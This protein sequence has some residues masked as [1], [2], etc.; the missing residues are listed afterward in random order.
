[1]KSLLFK[2]SI[3]IVLVGI[4]Y[5]LNIVYTESS[6]SKQ[7]IEY[8]WAYDIND[9]DL[10][11]PF[12]FERYSLHRYVKVEVS[13]NNLYFARGTDTPI[14]L[15]SFNRVSGKVNW[16]IQLQNRW[17][18]DTPFIINEET[19]LLNLENETQIYASHDGSFLEK[20]LNPDS[21]RK[22]IYCDHEK[23]LFED[24]GKTLSCW[25]RINQKVI[26][27]Y[28]LDS[29][30]SYRLA[31]PW[32][33][34]YVI[35]LQ[36][37]G[38]VSL[39]SL[40]FQNGSTTEFA[41]WKES[42]LRM[43]L[44]LEDSIIWI[45]CLYRDG[46]INIESVQSEGQKQI[47]ASFPRI[48]SAEKL[49]A[50]SHSLLS[51]YEDLGI[52]LFCNQDTK[53]LCTSLVEVSRGVD[54]QIIAVDSSF[55]QIWKKEFPSVLVSRNILDKAFLDESM[56]VFQYLSRSQDSMRIA[57]SFWV[58]L[59]SGNI[60]Q[61]FY[62]TM[63]Y[64]RGA[65][66]SSILFVPGVFLVTAYPESNYVTFLVGYSYQEDLLYREKEET[67]SCHKIEL[68]SLWEK[69]YS[70]VEYC[71]IY[72]SFLYKNNICFFSTYYDPKTERREAKL[73]QYDPIERKELESIDFEKFEGYSRFC[74]IIEGD[75]LITTSYDNYTKK[76][77]LI[78]Y[79]LTTGSTLWKKTRNVVKQIGELFLTENQTS[80]SHSFSLYHYKD[81]KPKWTFR[82]PSSEV[83][84][85]GINS[86]NQ[87]FFFRESTI[88]SILN[89]EDGSLDDE[90]LLSYPYGCD[91][92]LMEDFLF[93]RTQ[94]RTIVCF[95]I[96]AKKVVWEKDLGDYFQC[97][98]QEDFFSSYWKG[99]LLSQDTM[100]SYY[101]NSLVFFD[102]IHGKPLYRLTHDPSPINYLKKIDSHRFLITP[103]D[104][105]TK[106]RLIEFSLE[107][108]SQNI[109]YYFQPYFLEYGNFS[110]EN[111]Y[112]IQGETYFCRTY[113]NEIFHISKVPDRITPQD[114]GL[115]PVKVKPE[116][117]NFLY[118]NDYLIFQSSIGGKN[119]NF[120]LVAY[121]L[122]TGEITK[123][124]KGVHERFFIHKDLLFFERWG[125][126]YCC[127]VGNFS[128]VYPCEY[129]PEPPKST[130]AGETY[131]PSDQKE[132]LPV[133]LKSLDWY[134]VNQIVSG[135]FS[136]TDE[137]EQLFIT[138]DT[139]QCKIG[140]MQ[141]NEELGLHIPSITGELIFKDTSY[142]NK[143]D[144][145]F[146]Q[147]QIGNIDDDELDELFIMGY[148]YFNR[149]AL[150][151]VWDYS[152]SD[153]TMTAHYAYI[154]NDVFDPELIVENN[155][156]FCQG[157]YYNDKGEKYYQ[158][159]QIVYKPSKKT[160]Y[161]HLEV[162]E[163]KLSQLFP[164]QY[165]KA[166]SNFQFLERPI[167]PEEY[168]KEKPTSSIA[169]P[170]V[171]MPAL[172]LTDSTQT[173]EQENKYVEERNQYLEK[174]IQLL[175][176]KNDPFKG[177]R[178]ESFSFDTSRSYTISLQSKEI[179]WSA[180]EIVITSI[181]AF[182]LIRDRGKNYIV[183]KAID[184][185]DGRHIILFSD[186]FQFLDV[187]STN[188][189]DAEYDAECIVSL[190]HPESFWINT[191]MW[192]GPY[193]L[194]SFAVN[195]GKLNGNMMFGYPMLVKKGEETFF[196][197]IDGFH[198]VDGMGRGS[199][200]DGY[201]YYDPWSGQ[202]CSQL[203][204]PE[205]RD[206]LDLLYAYYFFYRSFCVTPGKVPY[207]DTEAILYDGRKKPVYISDSLYILQNFEFWFYLYDEDMS[208]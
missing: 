163:K 134:Y 47:D 68:E 98:I 84:F 208:S 46:S 206:Q 113:Q 25:D 165:G 159:H 184:S 31:G 49:K 70:E 72:Q 91:V 51:E 9:L 198:Y 53:Y 162:N 61:S 160:N 82:F 21:T 158:C 34:Q 205:M 44:V 150:I 6:T 20:I 73:I 90:I 168:W 59:T 39:L 86:K 161:S 153:K 111:R 56:L 121:N 123:I 185:W 28:R 10:D 60:V 69:N 83:R 133:Q 97:F 26:W 187:F 29:Y 125:M 2:K 30:E 13:Q 40:D 55:Q 178:I 129:F 164:H 89:L 131:E 99:Y 19:I 81:N 177:I 12:S 122:K 140:I 176:Q 120:Y 117:T 33:N 196:E 127:L 54:L 18:Q 135:H 143:S 63:D 148:D 186:Q 188:G 174:F 175:N 107:D 169:F 141:K 119:S 147:S 182:L 156:I 200:I 95:N 109:E 157:Y 100:I 94:Y 138:G 144:F 48:W 76:E 136:Q 32:E 118:Y 105:E 180:E 146:W 64:F 130:K 151:Y 126:Y 16:T 145:S 15:I 154:M 65:P 1:M 171:K 96:D 92:S 193:R 101:E 75:N 179:D 106:Q 42:P 35:L 132:D 67:Y 87:A 17:N 192:R 183:V 24:P 207:G 71:S 173:N 142:A 27:S 85:L 195:Q 5:F 108:S 152:E 11:Y 66:S 77:Y 204:L 194:C 103:Q 189:N 128:M 74:S 38:S 115:E 58:D 166:L 201:Q 93:F 78:C 203:F 8:S 116:C 149:S 102:L 7:P 191:S 172:L 36:Q 43:D 14:E 62:E 170:L 110:L 4:F 181:P 45:S 202:L 23:V 167:D 114:Q 79:Q 52:R 139:S 41:S 57:T 22:G 199:Y 80:N 88:I 112:T 3:A 190:K 104:F 137:E 37:A 50:Q 155:E 197:M 124:Q